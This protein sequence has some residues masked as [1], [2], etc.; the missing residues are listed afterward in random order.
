MDPLTAS[1]PVD[2]E[3]I[4]PELVRKF[5]QSAAFF[6]CIPSTQLVQQSADLLLGYMEIWHGLTYN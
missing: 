3:T 1:Y 2:D 5:T 4:E 6:A